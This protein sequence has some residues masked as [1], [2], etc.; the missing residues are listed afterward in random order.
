MAEKKETKLSL[1]VVLSIL[2]MI[3]SVIVGYYSGQIG[4]NNK[5]NEINLKYEKEMGELR[6]ELANMHSEVLINNLSIKTNNKTIE[7]SYILIDNQTKNS[8]EVKTL[9]LNY[10]SNN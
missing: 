1:S 6:L 2:G 10:M 7:K 8:D 4:V 3:I 5:M 9:L